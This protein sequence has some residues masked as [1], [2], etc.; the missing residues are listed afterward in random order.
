M[1]EEIKKVLVVALEGATRSD[2]HALVVQVIIS[3]GEGWIPG[4]V[5]IPGAA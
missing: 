3:G 5:L 4:A 1:P 2:I